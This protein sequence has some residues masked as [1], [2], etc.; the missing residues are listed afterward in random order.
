VT[1]MTLPSHLQLGPNPQALIRRLGKIVRHG[2]PELRFHQ[3]EIAPVPPEHG[4]E[5]TCTD[6]ERRVRLP[7]SSAARFRSAPPPSRIR[8]CRVLTRAPLLAAQVLFHVL[9]SRAPGTKSSGKRKLVLN[10]QPEEHRPAGAARAPSAGAAPAPSAG[11]APA[12]SA[13]AAPAPQTGRQTAMAVTAPVV[14]GAHPPAP[15]LDA[16]AAPPAEAMVTVCDARV[17]FGTASPADPDR[18]SGPAAKQRKVFASIFSAFAVVA[19]LSS[20]LNTTTS[21]VLAISRPMRQLSEGN[22]PGILNGHCLIFFVLVMWLFSRLFAPL[23]AWLQRAVV[24]DRLGLM[25]IDPKL[26]LSFRQAYHS[27]A[28]RGWLL[29]FAA[30]CVLALLPL[31]MTLVVGI[32]YFVIVLNRPETQLTFEWLRAFWVLAAILLAALALAKATADRRSI[33]SSCGGR[34]LGIAEQFVPALPPSLG[35]DVRVAELARGCVLCAAC[36]LISWCPSKLCAK[37]GGRRYAE[38]EA[39]KDVLVWATLYQ[40][41]TIISDSSRWVAAVL[42]VPLVLSAVLAAGFWYRRLCKA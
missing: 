10:R 20:N 40:T 38:V 36:C 21:G 33:A 8:G 37:A 19:I 42:E 35:S 17:V 15:A 34:S 14:S 29:Q 12:P 30:V 9:P 4:G 32:V 27:R 24:R 25:I 41:W 1:Q 31:S 2:L 16:L 13:G 18:D 28:V 23:G 11:A 6:T 3:Y 5:R 7:S 26:P 39:F 22:V